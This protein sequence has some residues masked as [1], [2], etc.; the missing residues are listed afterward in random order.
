[1]MTVTD[2]IMSSIISVVFVGN[3]C[4]LHILFMIISF[5]TDFIFNS[6]LQEIKND[7]L[8]CI[9]YFDVCLFNISDKVY[10]SVVSLLLDF[11]SFQ[12]VKK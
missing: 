10:V 12:G 8:Q 7:L 1:M 5:K 9:T 2:S 4:I 11:N 6:I 3:L